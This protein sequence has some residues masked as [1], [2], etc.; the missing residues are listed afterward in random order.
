MPN[1]YL[2]VGAQ[3]SRANETRNIRSQ[4][5]KTKIYVIPLI[6]HPNQM[7]NPI[8]RPPLGSIK[9]CHGKW[10]EQNES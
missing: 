8:I 9:D 4:S 7:S 2:S 5:Y 10:T 6:F 3:F 1:S